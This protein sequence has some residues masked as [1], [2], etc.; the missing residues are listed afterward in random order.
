MVRYISSH[1][2]CIKIVRVFWSPFNPRSPLLFQVRNRHADGP[3]TRRV[4][5]PELAAAR[6]ASDAPWWSRQPRNGAAD[7]W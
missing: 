3:D 1:H 4:E 2:A 5:P 7:S 6:E